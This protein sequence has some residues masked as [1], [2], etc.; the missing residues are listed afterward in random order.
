MHLRTEVK[1]AVSAIR[2][3]LPEEDQTLLIL[4]VDRRMAWNDIAL[5]VAGPDAE[6]DVVKRE[7]ARLR[8]RFQLVKDEL[9]ERVRKAGLTS[10]G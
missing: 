8:K 6:T 3:S 4:R 5:V 9:R 1:D 2:R 7:C 10:E